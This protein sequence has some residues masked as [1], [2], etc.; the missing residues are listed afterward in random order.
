MRL[1][2]REKSWRYFPGILGQRSD[3]RK[4]NPGGTPSPLTETS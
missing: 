4:V 3:D 2:I 1:E